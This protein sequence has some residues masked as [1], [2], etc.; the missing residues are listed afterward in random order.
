MMIK[1]NQLLQNVVQYSIHHIHINIRSSAI[2]LHIHI[3]YVS[4]SFNI[5]IGVINHIHL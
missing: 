5:H 4:L 3:V 1:C 2:V